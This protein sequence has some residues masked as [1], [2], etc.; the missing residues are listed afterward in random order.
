MDGW[1]DEYT[2]L[3]K[4]VESLQL[5]QKW[6][7][8]RCAPQRRSSAEGLREP[9][10]WVGPAQRLHG[11]QSTQEKKSCLNHLSNSSTI[12]SSIPSLHS[13]KR[14]RKKLIVLYIGAQDYLQSI[15]IIRHLYVEPYQLL[16]ENGQPYE[17]LTW[18][19]FF[20]FRQ[21][22][23]GGRGEPLVRNDIPGFLL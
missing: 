23:F 18:I 14:K 10:F 4:R 21:F 3:G 9:V 12:K 6:F 1:I 19:S 22:V 11:K 15:L 8:T 2:N 7:S 5:W 20:C 17:H 13:I 16:R